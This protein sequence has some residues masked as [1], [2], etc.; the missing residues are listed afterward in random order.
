MEGQAQGGLRV[1]EVADLLGVPVRKL[2]YLRERGIVVPSIGGGKGNHVRYSAE[3][4]LW[5][6]VVV[7]LAEMPESIQIPPAET[8]TDPLQIEGPDGV[9]IKLPVGEIIEAVNY[10]GDKST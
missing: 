8:W 9:E 4:I 5:A 2:K 10:R 6:K 7:I 3:D 1:S